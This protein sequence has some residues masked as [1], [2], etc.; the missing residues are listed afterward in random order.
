M[1]ALAITPLTAISL[2]GCQ[3]LDLCAKRDDLYPVSGGGNKGRK[4][5]RF[6]VSIRKQRGD[7]LVSCGGLQ[8]NHARVVALTAAA[9]RW[10]CRL[11]LHGDP[12][13][14]KAPA[15]NL[16]LMLLAGARVVVTTPDLMATELEQAMALFRSEGR[17]PFQ[18]P[19]GGHAW[20][21]AWAYANAIDELARQC[22]DEPPD[23]I[24]LASGTG[25]TQAG[26][27][28]GV[29][30][31]GWNTRVIGISVARRNPQGVQSV[32]A[33]YEQVRAHLALS[34]PPRRIEFFDEFVGEGYEQA[35][36]E[37]WETIR[38]V[39]RECGLLLD[40]TY[41]GK[42]FH[43]LTELVRRG[44]IPASGRVVFWHT[45]GLLNLCAARP[46]FSFG[47]ARPCM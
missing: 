16:L 17:N 19:G 5:A 41:T 30:R 43:G 4:M 15:G 31:R 11:V 23:A 26:L 39:A 35:G 13:A 21:G 44:E 38:A 25:T 27:M 40:P 1:T 45:G 37:V 47:E 36:A 9:Q 18:I 32:G 10:P 28:A 12:A 2:A 46:R 34:G 14:L 22:G 8:S 42:A 7:A 3:G 24:V 6:L 33:A 20:E 29:E